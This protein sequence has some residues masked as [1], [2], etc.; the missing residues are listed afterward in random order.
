MKL[1]FKLSFEN[2]YEYNRVYS[3]ISVGRN[4]DAIFKAGIF[5]AIVGAVI[6]A[7]FFAGLLTK[8]TSLF[9]GSVLCAVGVFAII[10]AK[11]I[12][13][14]RLK[15]EVFRKYRTNNYFDVERTVEFLDTQFLAYSENDEYRGD[16]DEDIKEFIETE[17][18]FL[19]MVRG[20][21][22]VI[23]P[24]DSVNENEVRSTIRRIAEE[25]EIGRRRI[26]G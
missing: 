15:K 10:Y 22:G 11:L 6:L 21:R 5:M 20:R 1:N 26:K 24:K 2:Y 14:H 25:Y 7:C 19:I 23:I 17:N 18:L 3:K 13:N 4:I 16:Y 8:T 9:L 12:F